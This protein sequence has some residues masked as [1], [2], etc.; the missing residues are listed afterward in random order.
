M[1]DLNSKRRGPIENLVHSQLLLLGDSHLGAFRQAL[2]QA[3]FLA[4]QYQIC[5]LRDATLLGLRNPA[6][7]TPALGAFRRFLADKN[8]AATVLLQLG[9]ADCGF[10]MW[11]RVRKFN[12]PIADQLRMVIAAYLSLIHELRRGGFI[13]IVVT[14]AVPPV[15]ADPA[16]ATHFPEE[17]REITASYGERLKLTL[18]HNRLLQAH[19]RDLGLRYIDIS[20]ELIDPATKAVRIECRSADPGD[21]Y[22]DSLAAG[23][24]WAGKLRGLFEVD[25]RRRPAA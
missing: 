16:L 4:W 22:L 15:I 25:N 19:A 17:R 10:A 2:P 11:H 12:E 14:G 23:A 6:G 3:G 18:D 20:S 5:E 8:R 24:L 9:E 13:D 7:V 1:I 21:H